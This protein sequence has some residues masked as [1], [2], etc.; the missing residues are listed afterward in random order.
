[1]SKS[2]RNYNSG[3]AE[4]ELDTLIRDETFLDDTIRNLEELLRQT[5]EKKRQ[6]QEIIKKKKERFRKEFGYMPKYQPDDSKPSDLE[7]S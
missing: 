2:R 4:G 6:V 7:E 3:K 1:M 5:T